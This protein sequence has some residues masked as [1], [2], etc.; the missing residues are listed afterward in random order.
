[1]K[2][3]ALVAEENTQHPADGE[4]QLAAGDVQE[5]FFPHPLAPFL[6]PL[7]MTGGTESPGAA[8]EVEKKFKTTVLT[9]CPG[10]A[11]ARIVL[12]VLNT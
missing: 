9:A 3:P 4:D 5:K 8:G 1:L 12:Q 11:A 10:K 7:Q 6:K 2:K